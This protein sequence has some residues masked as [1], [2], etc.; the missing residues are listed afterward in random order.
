MFAV[1]EWVPFPKRSRAIHSRDFLHRDMRRLVET[2]RAKRS[3]RPDLLDL[4]I[5]A[6]DPKS[7]RSMT[8]AEVVR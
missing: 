7:G 8:D 6:R 2:R 1:P 5:A 3:A 4:L